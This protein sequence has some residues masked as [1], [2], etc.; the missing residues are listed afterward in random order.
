MRIETY[1]T[2]PLAVNTY[3]AWDETGIAVLVDPG[4]FDRRIMDS[5]ARNELQV[6]YILLTH[7]H[8]DHIGGVAEFK[9][10]LPGAL[11]IAMAAERELLED[12]YQNA[13]RELLG[14]PLS[15]P[16][17]LYVQDGETL[18]V[19]NTC[20]RFL[21]TPGHSRGGMCIVTKGVCF[22]GDTLFQ[23]SVGRTDFYGGDMEQLMHSIATKLY[24]LPDDTR[25]YPG[26]MG[27]T[28]I[29]F[30]KRYNPFVRG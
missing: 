24:T 12:P 9:R 6:P 17:D 29:G 11:V 2:G 15:V 10:Q 13:S 16:A 30:E 20:Y 1:H 21:A 18:T 27:E 4:G 7:G 28:N 26:H 25:V 8:C 5:V 19:G 14:R 22:S 23:G 3:L